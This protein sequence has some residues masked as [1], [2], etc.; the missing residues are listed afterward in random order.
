MRGQVP[1]RVLAIL[2]LCLIACGPCR[3]QDG[4]VAGDERL[5]LQPEEGSPFAEEVKQ[6]QAAADQAARRLAFAAILTKA[7]DQKRDPD[8]LLSILKN[9]KPEDVFKDLLEYV[10]DNEAARHACFIP[11]LVLAAND[12]GDNARIAGEAVVAYKRA[13]LPVITTMLKSEVAGERIAAAAS[14][15]RRIGG[16]AGAAKLIPPLVEALGRK[17]TELSTVAMRSLSR[18]AL[19]NHKTAEEWATWLDGKSELDLIVEIADRENEAR[20]KAEEDRSRIEKELLEVLL[21]RM[22]KDE[23]GDVN[24][25]VIRLNEAKYLLVRLEAVKLLKELL[26][27]SLTDDAAKAP[28]EALGKVL[29]TGTEPEE[30]RK[31]CANALAE[32]GKPA[33]AFPFIDQCLA[34]NGISSDLR[35][36]LVRGLNSPL[37]ATRLT[38]LLRAELDGVE[39]RSNT[40]L[41]TLIT[42]AR[43]VIADADQS[44]AARAIIA[45]LDRL[46]KL[47]AD[48]LAATLEA[49][50]RKRYADLAV[51]ACDTLAY[52]ARLRNVDIVACTASL[53]QLG[54]TEIPSTDQERVSLGALSTLREAIPKS[55]DAAVLDQ[56]SKPPL[57]EKLSALYTRLLGGPETSAQVLIK[58]IQVYQEMGVA[59]EPASELQ[60]R[61]LERARS[62]EAVLPENP[63]D[64]RTLRDALRSLL[65]RLNKS[66]VEHAALLKEL[67]GTQYGDKDVLGYLQALKGSRVE[68]INTAFQPII[69]TH[70]VRIALIIVAL[71]QSKS[72]SSDEAATR[73]YQVFRGGLTAA[74]K[75]EFGRSI[76]SAL[77]NGLPEEEKARLA[78]GASGPL[79]DLWMPV[80]IE[81]LRE[82][83]EPGSNRDTVS[84]ILLSSLKQAHPGKYDNFALVGQAKEAFTK[85]LD[86]ITKQMKNDGYAV[87]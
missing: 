64:P 69:E 20:R 73:E 1:I 16:A 5:Q 26:K 44:E 57:S 79:R 31:S 33:L 55:K 2:G 7:A 35:L 52:L 70:A 12:P 61:L 11:A 76:S 85:A 39:A 83:A 78:T 40:L 74:V 87:P 24:A 54:C 51:R 63:D 71:E 27:P 22:R 32:C 38:E 28:I 9:K 46:L 81:K 17:E 84:E 45:E 21:E 65:A 60:R 59:P 58:L 18:L 4:A 68:V 25:L 48:K 23:R 29:N 36:E 75:G 19:L 6:L 14:A 41:E 15:G 30:L 10:R 3:A 56:L 72:W 80:A 47:T 66:A 62:T 34:A 37:A 13:A 42:Q 77:K 86:E 49:P 50:A 53:V 43:S 67:L 8:P 82:N